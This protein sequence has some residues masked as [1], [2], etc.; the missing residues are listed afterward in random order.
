MST[1][2]PEP[3][4]LVKMESMHFLVEGAFIQNLARKMFWF[5]DNEDGAIEMMGDF[6]G[7]TEKEIMAVL[8]GDAEITG[9]GICDR[10]DCSQCKGLTA[11]KLDFIPNKKFKKEIAKRVAWLTEACYKIG[12]FHIDKKCIDEYLEELV[13][14]GRVESRDNERTYDYIAETVIPAKKAS[15]YNRTGY[16]MPSVSFVPTPKQ[17]AYKFN[18]AIQ[19]WFNDV[20]PQIRDAFRQHDV[21]VMQKVQSIKDAIMEK[22]VKD[23]V[24][25]DSDG[26][27]EGCT[28]FVIPNPADNFNMVKINCPKE[29][30]I[31]YMNN[32]SRTFYSV[33]FTMTMD[34]DKELI[35][36]R[37]INLEKQLGGAHENLMHAMGLY[38]SESGYYRPDELE[39]MVDKVVDFCIE[40]IAWMDTKKVE[41]LPNVIEFRNISKNKALVDVYFDGELQQQEYYL[42][43]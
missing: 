33:Q 32:R 10:K 15:I 41:K 25:M 12:Q 35:E 27:V 40:K 43:V 23:A 5:E 17:A 14:L 37:M 30:L 8:H 6:Q 4:N 11:I 16:R 21:P 42:K 22:P 1:R 20:E 3:K 31:D 29:N 2:L 13:N 9:W 28:L 18:V 39:Y 19:N 36:K 38:H 26:R 24:K 34:K 7:I